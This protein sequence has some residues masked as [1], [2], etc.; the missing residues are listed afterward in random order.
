MS[1]LYDAFPKVPE[2]GEGIG[3]NVSRRKILVQCASI[4]NDSWFSSRVIAGSY[5]VQV[6]TFPVL[7]LE[8][9]CA[10]LILINLKTKNKKI[11]NVFSG[12]IWT[13]ME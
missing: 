7:H 5:I 8:L 9:S 3:A 4:I 1:S 2:G 10:S 13:N 12:N 6:L 11:I